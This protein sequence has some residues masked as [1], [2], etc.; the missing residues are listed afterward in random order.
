M[1]ECKCS[2][3]EATNFSLSRNGQPNLV[4]QIL[5]KGGIGFE[6]VG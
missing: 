4:T 5:G 2:V 3:N 1:Y 6:A